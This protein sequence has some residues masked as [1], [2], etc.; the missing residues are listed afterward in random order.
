MRNVAMLKGASKG[1]D[2]LGHTSRFAAGPQ[3]EDKHSSGRAERP[4]RLA[5]KSRI[6]QALAT[7]SK[8]QAAFR[9]CRLLRMSRLL[10]DRTKA[11]Y[12]AQA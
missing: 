4:P 7:S 9:V 6:H 5:R 3:S 10:L 12:T 8:S 11:R 2:K 1:G